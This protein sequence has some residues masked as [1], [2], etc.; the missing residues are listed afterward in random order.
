LIRSVQLFIDPDDVVA[1]IDFDVLGGLSQLDVL[2]QD[3]G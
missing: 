2:R 3:D 1:E